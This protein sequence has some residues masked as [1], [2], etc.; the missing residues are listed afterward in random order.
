MGAFSICPDMEGV[1]SYGVG[2]TNTN[3]KI[4]KEFTNGKH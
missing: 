3:Q 1:K 2:E 4:G